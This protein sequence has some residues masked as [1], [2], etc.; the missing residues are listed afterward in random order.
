MIGSSSC[1]Q[2]F[3]PVISVWLQVI[4]GV[5]DILRYFQRAANS[6]GFSYMKTLRF[7]STFAMLALATVVTAGSMYVTVV[8]AAQQESTDSAVVLPSAA[9]V[10]DIPVVTDVADG[11]G[12][13]AAIEGLEPALDKTQILR[14][15][16]G[17]HHC[18]KQTASLFQRLI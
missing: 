12:L 13:D 15:Q 10:Q 1:P 7:I 8:A 18:E 14:D 6:K 2:G 9:T 5:P 16:V 4:L 11:P 17:F 3:P